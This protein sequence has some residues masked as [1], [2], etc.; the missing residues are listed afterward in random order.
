MQRRISPPRG[1]GKEEEKEIK[2]RTVTPHDGEGK[3]PEWSK[4]L[5]REMKELGRKRVS[6]AHSAWR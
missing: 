1:I 2:E 3:K 6:D 5:E 4:S